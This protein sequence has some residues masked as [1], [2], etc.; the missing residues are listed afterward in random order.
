MNTLSIT[1]IETAPATSGGHHHPEI[2]FDLRIDEEPHPGF[3]GLSIDPGA[4][5]ESH[6]DGE[7][8]VAT[9]GCG[10]PDCAGVFD[11]V[12][13]IHD[14]THVH[15]KIPEPYA[16]ADGALQPEPMTYAEFSFN[17][18]EY[19]QQLAGVVAALQ[20][21]VQR[22]EAGEQFS[23]EANAGVSA[24]SIL[25]WVLGGTTASR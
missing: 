21:L 22:E 4:F 17:A 10:V 12:T 16:L 5:V 18:D 6:D 24:S 20:G 11:G 1:L 2:S 3:A 13:V 19:H 15:W 8:F 9:C 25:K 23:I 7:F 14:A